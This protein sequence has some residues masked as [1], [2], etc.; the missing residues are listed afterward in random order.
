[1]NSGYQHIRAPF[2]IARV[3]VAEAF[4]MSA[5]H[6]HS[7]YEIYVLEE[8]TREYIIDDQ[9]VSVRAGDVVLIPPHA[10]HKT[11]GDGFQRVLLY[12]ERAYLERYFTPEALEDLL[13]CFSH[14]VLHPVGDAAVYLQIVLE[15]LLR[16]DEDTAYLDLASLLQCLGRC[17]RP[18]D[19]RATPNTQRVTQ[20]LEYINQHYAEIEEI[21]QIAEQFYITKYHLCRI[22][23]Q[24]AG[25]SLVSY[26]NHVR[27]RQAC[28]LLAESRTSVTR[29]STACGFHSP[30]Y[31]SNVFKAET[32]YT[33]LQYR[34]MCKSK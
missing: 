17:K 3:R 10:L 20:I 6:Y 5:M 14:T 9:C 7:A 32:G 12:F 21:S 13:D 24:A 26:L 15:R 27:I 34:G 4:N 33:P 25:V 16:A 23:K 19:K 22:F 2:D 28:K 1:M 18:E 31:F 8:G 11:G 30:N 29:I